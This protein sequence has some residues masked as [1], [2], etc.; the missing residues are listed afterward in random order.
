M[1]VDGWGSM[2]V[3]GGGRTSFR[4]HVW[5]S[6]YLLQKVRLVLIL[7]LYQ[8]HVWKLGGRYGRLPSD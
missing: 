7:C 4:H 6:V 1:G 5:G 8:F 2:G 3:D